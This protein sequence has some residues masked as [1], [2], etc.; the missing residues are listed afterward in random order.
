MVCCSGWPVCWCWG[1]KVLEHGGRLVEAARQYRIAPSE[2][3]DLSTAINPLGW[4]VPPIPPSMW[5]RLPQDEDGLAEV[6]GRYYQAAQVLPVA[7]SQAAIQALPRLRRRGRVG[8]CQ[9]AY[10]EHAHAWRRA[11]HEVVAWSADDSLDGLDVLVLVHPNNPTGQT[12]GSA[13]LL[14]WHAQLAAHGGWLV[15]DEAFID[16]TP[17]ASLAPHSD[18]P[19]LIV[20][21][22]LGKFFGLAG[23]RV[24]FVAAEAPLLSALQELLGPWTVAGAARW[25]AQSALADTDWQAQTRLD[26]ARAGQALAQLLGANGLLPTGGS[27]LFQWVT[28]PQAAA[29]HQGLARQGILTRYFETPASLRFGLPGA[30]VEWQ[31]LEST[32]KELVW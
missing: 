22:S 15:L 13:Q 32:L 24:G 12:Y 31:R 21:R 27:A 18:R 3:L 8:L 9:P 28:T 6:A 19:G 29:I 16:A 25:L 2:W 23:A 4:P 20:L 26:L 10:A 17:A 11:G 5:T 1:Y 7:G 30:A 14:G